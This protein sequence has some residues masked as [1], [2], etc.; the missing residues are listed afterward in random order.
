MLPRPASEASPWVYRRDPQAVCRL[1]GGGGTFRDRTA[2]ISG[3]RAFP[4]PEGCATRSSRPLP[5]S[6]AGQFEVIG[7]A[8][9]TLRGSPSAVII[10]AD[11]RKVVLATAGAPPRAI[12]PPCI[13]DLAIHASGAI[14]NRAALNHQR[15]NGREGRCKTALSGLASRRRRAWR[16]RGRAGCPW[17]FPPVPFH[18]RSP[19]SFGTVVAEPPLAAR[20]E[21]AG[22]LAAG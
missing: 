18:R 11:F 15:P 6:G 17:P 10:C 13:K 12:M 14:E 16:K 22:D 5:A 7:R 8:V 19:P 21:P 9:N 1:R 20:H 4:S 2:G 3:S